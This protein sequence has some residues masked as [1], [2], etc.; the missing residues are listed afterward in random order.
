MSVKNTGIWYLHAGQDLDILWDCFELCDFFFFSLR[1]GGMV[2]EDLGKV[3][4]AH[5]FLT[6]RFGIR[7]KTSIFN[8]KNTSNFCSVKVDKIVK[9][10]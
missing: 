7:K 9:I 4:F 10:I 5:Q 1:V 2:F 3:S 6:G 8:C